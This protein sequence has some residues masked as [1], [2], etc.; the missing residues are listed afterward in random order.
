MDSELLNFEASVSNYEYSELIFEF[1]RGSEYSA[2]CSDLNFE[3][4][5]S[6]YEY[7]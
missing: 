3:A 7:S 5:A 4:S 1:Q 2:L 6:N